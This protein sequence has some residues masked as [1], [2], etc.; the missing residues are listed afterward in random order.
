S[1]SVRAGISLFL[2]GHEPESLR[3]SARR[4][5]RFPHR[6]VICLDEILANA[7]RTAD[8]G[9]NRCETDPSVERSSRAKNFSSPVC[10]S[11]FGAVL[12]SCLA[13]SRYSVWPC[14]FVLSKRHGS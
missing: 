9:T 3:R 1:Y 8:P 2:G 10:A 4:R 12:D 5:R 13:G 14:L 6:C 7:F 11:T